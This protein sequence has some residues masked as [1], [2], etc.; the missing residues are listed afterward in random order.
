MVKA[1]LRRTTR[2]ETTRRAAAIFRASLVATT[3]VLATVIVTSI[4]VATG[5]A[6][7]RSIFGGRQIASAHARALRAPP[8]TTLTS[9]T[10][11]PTSATTTVAA[12][13]STTISAAAIILAAAITTAC[14]ARRVVLSGIVMGRKI[15]RSGSVRIRLSLF[16]VMSIVVHF[17][18]VG[19]ESFVGTGLVFY[20]AGVL[21]VREGIVMRRFVIG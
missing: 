13:V 4:V 5:L 9:A 6:L 1:A 8:A 11:S 21:I 17:G 15:L 20:N 19:A 16:G 10:P 3:V 14:R 12:T 2:F 7:R 18:S